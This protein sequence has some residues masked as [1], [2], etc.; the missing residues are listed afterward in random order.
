[1]YIYRPGF[2][3][4]YYYRPSVGGNDRSFDNLFDILMDIN[5]ENN[6]NEIICDSNDEC[7]Y[8][9][10][11][12]F[13]IERYPEFRYF[14]N[15]ERSDVTFV[16]DGQRLPAFKALLSLRSPV[17]EE[18][19]SED[20][21]QKEIVVSDATVDG[22]ETM[23]LFLCIEELVLIEE[24]NVDLILD[25]Y[26]LSM[27]YQLKR[28]TECL[29]KYIEESV[30]HCDHFTYF[31]AFAD[32]RDFKSLLDLTTDYIQLNL[33]ELM[34]KDVDEF[35][36]DNNKTGNILFQSQV[37]DMKKFVILKLTLS[38]IKHINFYFY[39]K[40]QRNNRNNECFDNLFDS[41]V[42][43]DFEVYKGIYY[44]SNG[45]VSDREA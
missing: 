24:F 4:Y 22:F 19:F 27:K 42:Y 9:F 39:Y 5:E 23:L 33:D 2:Y 7:N 26:N 35:I 38:S 11:E 18:L 43:N 30:I 37:E 10:I 31:Y 25:V 14:L 29:D 15:E 28:L 8:S 20:P 13:N 1:M 36:Q 45:R 32:E 3:C 21:N 12:N 17:F 40:C 16:V 41:L 34:D 6:E 44:E